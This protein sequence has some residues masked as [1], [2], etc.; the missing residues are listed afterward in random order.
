MYTGVVYKLRKIKEEESQRWVVVGRDPET[1]DRLVDFQRK[2]VA[3][4]LEPE[5][6]TSTPN[7]VP[8]SGARAPPMACGG[9][10]SMLR[11]FITFALASFLGAFILFYLLVYVL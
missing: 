3:R 9:G 7:P 8:A 10:S 2:D 1:V 4:Q 11:N 6:R 5:S